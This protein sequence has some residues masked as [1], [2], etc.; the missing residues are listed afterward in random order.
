MDF[1]THI[2][3]WDMHQ[4]FLLNSNVY[5]FSEYFTRKRVMS[6]RNVKRRKIVSYPGW[7]VYEL[8]CEAAIGDAGN[9]EIPKREYENET[10]K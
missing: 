9:R 4:F 8:I 6:I 1:Y 3:A 7:N 2:G 10:G 5:F